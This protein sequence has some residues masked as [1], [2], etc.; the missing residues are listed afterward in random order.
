MIATYLDL[1]TCHI[2]QTTMDDLGRYD[3][4]PDFGWPAMSIAAYPHGAFCAIPDRFDGLPE[5]LERVL[6]YAKD[7][8]ASLVRLDSDGDATH[9]LPVYDW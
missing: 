1:S 3:S 4:W 5:D 9:N 8:G 7:M 2:E 6:R